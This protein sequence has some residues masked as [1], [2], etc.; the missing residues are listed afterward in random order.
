MNSKKEYEKDIQ[1]KRIFFDSRWGAH[2][3]TAFNI[4]LDNP[5]LGS[6]IKTFR[7]KCNDK[8]YENINSK[9]K[10]TRCNTH[11]HN[12]YLEIISEGGLILFLS[13]FYLIY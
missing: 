10:K 2:Y 9:S 4:F 11:P 5:L 12:I 3:L 6:G 8:K 1:D 13:F 7:I